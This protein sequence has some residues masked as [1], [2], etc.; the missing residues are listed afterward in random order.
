MRKVLQVE[1]RGDYTLRLVFDDGVAGVCTLAHLVGRGVFASWNDH[2][3][4]SAVKIGPHG[5]LVWPGDID[6][7]PDALYLKVTK[8]Q[9]AQEFPA[10]SRQVSHA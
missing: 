9:P 4:F 8:R 3:V 6:L 1:A 10:L 5:E 7:C 2:E